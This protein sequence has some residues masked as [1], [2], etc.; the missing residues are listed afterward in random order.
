MRARKRRFKVVAS[1]FLA[2]TL[3]TGCSIRFMYRQLDWL[4]PWYVY[5][6]VSLESTQRSLLE[7]RLLRQL[8]WH[9]TTQLPAYSE[10]LS[11]IAVDPVEALSRPSLDNHYQQLVRYWRILVGKLSP[12][13]AILLAT[14]SD[15]QIDELMASLEKRNQESYERIVSAEPDERA[16]RRI[17]KMVKQL[18]RW[19][20]PL[21]TVQIRRVERWG[22]DIGPIGLQWVESRRKWQETLRATLADRGDMDIFEPR[23]RELMVSPEKLWNAEFAKAVAQNEDKT[24]QLISKLVPMLDERQREHLKSRLTGWAEDFEVLACSEGRWDLD[25]EVPEASR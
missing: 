2:A 5:D 19:M 16:Q 9:C 8:E 4:V 15:A 7:Q 12:D 17:R 20:G 3:S 13:I 21:S 23:I 18:R 25:I 14:A 24:L 10:W 22:R 1:I 6:Y 11:E